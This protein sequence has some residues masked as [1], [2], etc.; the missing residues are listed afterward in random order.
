MILAGGRFDPAAWQELAWKDGRGILPA[1]LKPESYGM[2][3]DEAP[4]NLK[5]FYADYASMQHDIFLVEQEDP[6][7]L[8]AIYE[9]TPFFKTVRA[10]LS[11]ATL[12][13]FVAAESKR[14]AAEQ[15]FLADYAQRRDL[16]RANSPA[17]TAQQ[18][19]EERRYRQLEPAWWLGRSPLPLVDRSVSPAILA[20]R[21]Q[22]HSL[23]EFKGLDLPFVVERRMGAGRIL[24]VTTG[25]TSDWNLLRASGAMYLFHR[26]ISGLIEETLPVRNYEA[27][28]RIALPVPRQPDLRY[29]LTRPSGRQE[30]LQVEAL[31]SEVSGVQIRSPVM[32]GTYRIQAEQGTSPDPNARTKLDEWMFA[33]HGPV[34]ESDLTRISPEEL[35]TKVGRDEVRVLGP[36]EA[37]DLQGG[38]RRGQGLWQMCLVGVLIGLCAEMLLL[39]WPSLGRKEAA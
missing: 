9:S 33:V 20:E 32:S 35:S 16:G 19:E 6:E 37:I 12:T 38:A 39:A 4:E 24:L 30:T 5:P 1:P 3:P 10:D 7:Q 21:A 11:D 2:T 34:S 15:K 8:E 14:L 13:A 28:Q 31:T 36:D 25:V 27:G 18:E 22:P 26:M 29:T 17:E 23:A